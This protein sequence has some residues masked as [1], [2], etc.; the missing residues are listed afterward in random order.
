MK[1]KEAHTAPPMELDVRIYPN[2][3]DGPAVATA[4]VT[5]NDCFAIR[6]V[7]IMEGKNGLFF[8]FSSRKVNGEYRDVCFPCTKD[9]KQQF[10]QKVLNAYEQAQ[11]QKAQKSPEPQEGQQEAR[12]EVQEEAQEEAQEES[13]PTM[14]M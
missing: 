7:R 12:E 13:G 10:D 14:T 9:F 6:D 1:M 5:L 11:V 8:F 3:G 4:S 2:R